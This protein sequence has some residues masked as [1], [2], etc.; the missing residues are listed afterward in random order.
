MAGIEAMHSTCAP[1]APGTCPQQRA[2]ARLRGRT[3]GIAARDA[4]G[5]ER[6][7][8]CWRDCEA[9]GRGNF[10]AAQ[11]WMSHAPPPQPAGTAGYRHKSW[12]ATTSARML[13]VHSPFLIS[14]LLLSPLSPAQPR[15][16]ATWSTRER[17]PHR[18]SLVL[19][20]EAPHSML[21]TVRR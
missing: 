6:P 4:V 16:A 1:H 11:G 9:A 17:L 20:D 10:P 13:S 2:R 3:A 12:A 14:R 18:P 21:I 15:A 7:W 5:D 8:S 19:R